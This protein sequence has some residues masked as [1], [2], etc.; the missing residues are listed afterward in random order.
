MM[1][2]AGIA[3]KYITRDGKTPKTEDG[4][5]RICLA[6]VSDIITVANF[7]AYQDNGEMSG[8]VKGGEAWIAFCRII[9]LPAGEFRDVIRD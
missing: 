3:D 2:A 4:E 6:D 5:R 7:L 9:G 8:G 1:N